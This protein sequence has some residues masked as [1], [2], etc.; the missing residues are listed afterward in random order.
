MSL[1]FGGDAVGIC[2]WDGRKGKILQG[3][4]CSLIVIIHSSNS[5]IRAVSTV[6]EFTFYLMIQIPLWVYI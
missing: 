6:D 5:S 3:G 1:G 4:S 2:V